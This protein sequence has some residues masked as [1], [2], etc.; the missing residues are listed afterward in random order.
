MRDA[1]DKD[2][3]DRA[4]RALEHLLVHGSTATEDDYHLARDFGLRL[5]AR[6]RAWHEVESGASSPG[7]TWRDR[8]PLL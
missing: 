5:L 1:L 7:P 3:D 6:W 2:S 8:P 4:A